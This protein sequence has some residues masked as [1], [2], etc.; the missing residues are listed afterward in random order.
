[1]YIY[2][3]TSQKSLFI[4]HKVLQFIDTKTNQLQNALKNCTD[5]PEKN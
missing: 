4:G 5:I 3:H 2:I 1:M